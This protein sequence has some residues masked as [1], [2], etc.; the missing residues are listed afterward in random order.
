[1]FKSFS[2]LLISPVALFNAIAPLFI[3][4]VVF[5]FLEDNQLLGSPLYLAAAVILSAAVL[6]WVYRMIQDYLKLDE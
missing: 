2:K 5:M 3:V 1:M 4:F 6:Y